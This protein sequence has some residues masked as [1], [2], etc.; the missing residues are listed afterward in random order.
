MMDEYQRTMGALFAVF[1]CMRRKLGGAESFCFGVD[2]E[3][4]PLN[5]RSK[6]PR[7]SEEE[8]S[9]RQSF[10]NEVQWERIDELLRDAGLLC[11]SFEGHDEERVLAMLV[12]T[13]IHDIMKIGAIVPQVQEAFAPYRG[14]KAGE[15]IYDH[16]IALGYILDHHADALPSYAGL[17]KKQQESIRFTQCKMEYN[18]GWLVQVCAQWWCQV[19]RFGLLFLPLADRPRWCRTIPTGGLR[20]VR[21]EVP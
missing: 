17:P 7:R 9:K 16:D 8:C 10:F 18:M 6:Q 15:R 20:E 13:A 11:D 14:Y 3:W 1:W 2:D 5:A 19:L 21:V 4:E 12:L